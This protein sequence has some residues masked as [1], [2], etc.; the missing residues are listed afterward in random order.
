L[1]LYSFVRH[2]NLYRKTIQGAR[3]SR[4]AQT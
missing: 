2:E 4:D 1:G 3:T